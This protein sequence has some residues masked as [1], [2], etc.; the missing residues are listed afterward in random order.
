M[1][2][3]APRPDHL[4]A[5]LDAAV[6]PGEAAAAPRGLSDAEAM[7][8]LAQLQADS[9]SELDLDYTRMRVMMH[10]EAF[11]LVGTLRD[12]VRDDAFRSFLSDTQGAIEDHRE[13][14]RDVLN[15]L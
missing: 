2:E 10:Q 6:L 14:A 5:A 4:G 9:R 15:D 8:G 3:R 7:S 12:L 1:P 13:H 11:V